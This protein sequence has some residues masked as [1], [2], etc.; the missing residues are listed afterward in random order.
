MK[1]KNRNILFSV[2]TT[3]FPLQQW[4]KQSIGKI[5][6]RRELVEVFILT[7]KPNCLLIDFKL[8]TTSFIRHPNNNIKKLKRAGSCRHSS[9]SVAAAGVSRPHACS[10]LTSC[11]P[12]T[13]NPS[14]GQRSSGCGSSEPPGLRADVCRTERTAHM[15]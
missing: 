14:V 4:L 5:L 7:I 1:K 2:Y 9:V 13:Q 15:E 11:T 6:L 12:V 10:S 8:F 3:N